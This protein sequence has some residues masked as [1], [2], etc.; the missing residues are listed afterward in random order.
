MDHTE[1][2]QFEA[3][4]IAR[5]AVVTAVTRTS[6]ASP[7]RGHEE[8]HQVHEFFAGNEHTFDVHFEKGRGVSRR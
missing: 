2:C 4:V 6:S 3:D 1:R 7:R 5:L 8:H